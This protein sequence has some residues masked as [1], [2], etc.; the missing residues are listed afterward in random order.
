MLDY[1]QQKPITLNG[2][3]YLKY[4]S[5]E[6]KTYVFYELSPQPLAHAVWLSL[7]KLWA[8][9]KDKKSNSQ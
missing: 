9:F 2:K 8:N 3:V 5:T 7:D 1:M 6:N 4:N